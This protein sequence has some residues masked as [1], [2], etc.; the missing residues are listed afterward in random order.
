MML[1][2][3]Q[4]LYFQLFQIVDAF[5]LC[6]SLWVAH[7]IRYTLIPE[8]TFLD[9]SSVAPFSGY[10]WMLVLIIPLGPFILERQG[11]YRLQYG[12]PIYKNLIAAARGVIVLVLT[13]AVF[14]VVFR[15]PQ[16]TVS[17]AALIM[18]IPVATLALGVREILSSELVNRRRRSAINR[19]IFC[20]AAPGSIW[21]RGRRIWINHPG[22]CTKSAAISI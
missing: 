22:R 7:T 18:F 15:V 4:E 19:S 5:L 9:V 2:R 12:A 1:R 16:S 3:H 17:R 13:L 20:S 21:N 8:M 11:F 14:I 10:I 6:A